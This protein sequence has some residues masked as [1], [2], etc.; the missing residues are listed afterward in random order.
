MPK[1]TPE[2]LIN[3][4][5]VA[6]DLRRR[7]RGLESTRAAVALQTG[8]PSWQ[9]V[10]VEPF[11][12][13]L[14]AL[15][16]QLMY[17][18]PWPLRKRFVQWVNLKLSGHPA[19]EDPKL[20][21]RAAETVRL[22]HLLKTKTGR[23]P[24]LFVLTS[25]PDTEGPLE[26]LRFELVRQGFEIAD[27]YTEARRPKAL[28]R[29]HPKAFVAIDP[30]A[31][32][33]VPAA[34][35]GFYSGWMHRIYMA[36]DRQ[37]STQSWIQRHFLLRDTGY[38]KIVWRLLACLRSDVPVVMVLSGGLPYNARFLYAARE[39]VQRLSPPRW[40][41]PKR[42]AQLEILN[43]LMKPEG[44]A[45]PADTGELP[46]STQQAIRSALE[47]W[48]IAAE[49]TGA[50][51]QEFAEEFKLPV[52]YRARLMRVLEARFA[53]RGKPLIVVPVSHGNTPP[54]VWVEPPMSIPDSA[55]VTAFS[56]LFAD[57][58]TEK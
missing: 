8:T 14:G 52:P 17:F 46:A 20:R 1:A 18:L 35:A 39:F 38:E 12:N 4:V 44:N 43:L 50:L 42:Q 26:W 21:E 45:W 40:K 10:F 23:W 51:L 41:V 15:W 56:K 31:L 48:G 16:G 33:T 55:D 47:R 30:F 54:H 11:F 37:P 19:L 29:P 5:I 28:F 6:D 13:V 25:H 58:L 7:A 3:A 27:A 49:K 57:R 9:R 24:A 32:D 53:S 2:A 36:W 22:A 34:A